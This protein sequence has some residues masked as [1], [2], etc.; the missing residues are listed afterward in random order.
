[1]KTY[2]IL[3]KIPNQPYCKRVELLING[4]SRT[5]G[6]LDLAGDGTFITTKKEKHLFK[7]LGALGLNYQL[8]TDTLID[9]EDIII[10]Y[11]D[12][13]LKTKRNYFLEKGVVMK[14][15]GFELQCFLPLAEF[16]MNKAEQLKRNNEYLQAN[17]FDKGVLA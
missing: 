15:G 4:K 7:K 12:E 13:A 5:I 11:N 16:G 8:L 9:F 2:L 14:F 1:M 6:K 3:N 10:Y 17:L